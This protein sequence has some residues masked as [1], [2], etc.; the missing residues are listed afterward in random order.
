MSQQTGGSGR[1]KLK[2][3]TGP[4]PRNVALCKQIVAKGSEAFRTHKDGGNQRKTWGDEKE[5][6]ATMLKKRTRK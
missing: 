5:G 6:I 1:P 2:W 3:E 4:G